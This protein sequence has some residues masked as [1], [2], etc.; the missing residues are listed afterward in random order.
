MAMNSKEEFFRLAAIEYVERQGD[1][2]KQEAAW[3]NH[4]AHY[5]TE[6]LERRVF[7]AVRQRKRRFVAPL[8]AT[9]ACLA[10]MLFGGRTFFQ[11]ILNFSNIREPITQTPDD[12]QLISLSFQ[13]PS[14]FTQTGAEQDQGKSIY[15][16]DDLQGD[17]VVLTL[18][19]P[20]VPID[21]SSFTE[22]DINDA[23]VYAASREGY[24]MMTFEKDNLSYTLTCRYDVNTL[25]RFSEE[26]L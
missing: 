24:Q 5:P 13:V 7:K 9:A 16:F 8:V 25:L 17:N 20:E 21:E 19:K 1:A 23:S 11:N 4:E 3:V 15:Y 22:L 2:L 14:G 6:N 26:I 10:L 18:E 12:R